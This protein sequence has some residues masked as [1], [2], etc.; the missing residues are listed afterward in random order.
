MAER[1]PDTNWRAAVFLR[2]QP[3]YY[4]PEKVRL[5]GAAGAEW[6]SLVARKRRVPP[7]KVPTLWIQD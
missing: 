7:L 6:N 1:I 3:I 4:S 5:R 2:A